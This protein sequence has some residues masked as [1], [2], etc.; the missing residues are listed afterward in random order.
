MTG[1][2]ARLNQALRDATGH[3]QPAAGALLA[4]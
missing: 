4:S 2:I 1:E 3:T